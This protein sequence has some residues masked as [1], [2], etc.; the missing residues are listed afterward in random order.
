M[1][2]LSDQNKK[3]DVYSLGMTLL[4]AF[5][6]I[7]LIERKKAAPY[8]RFYAQEY[9]FLEIISKMICKI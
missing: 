5:Y 6:L 1:N 8:N 4:A 7:L 3:S 2:D 9:P